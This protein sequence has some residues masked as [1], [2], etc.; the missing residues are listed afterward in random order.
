MGLRRFW[1]ARIGHVGDP[2]GNILLAVRSAHVE[3]VTD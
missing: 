1:G 2:P 3:I